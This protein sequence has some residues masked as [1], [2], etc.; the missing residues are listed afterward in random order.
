[1]LD[2][3]FKYRDEFAGFGK[4]R[5]LVKWNEESQKKEKGNGEKVGVRF[6]FTKLELTTQHLWRIMLTLAKE[7][8]ALMRSNPTPPKILEVRA[9]EIGEA[10]RKS[11]DFITKMQ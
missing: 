8:K 10:G 7:A 6:C 1:M 2:C 11:D 9:R 4:H 5:Q 3:T